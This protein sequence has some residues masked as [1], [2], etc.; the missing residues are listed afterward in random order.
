VR[1]ALAPALAGGAPVAGAG[2]GPAGAGAGSAA[3][4]AEGVGHVAAGGMAQA[5]RTAQRG[6]LTTFDSMLSAYLAYLVL[7][8]DTARAAFLRERAGFKPTTGETFKDGPGGL[9]VMDRLF[10][11]ILWVTTTGTATRYYGTNEELG[12]TLFLGAFDGDA[13]GLARTA[14][15]DTPTSNGTT[16]H[17][18][19][20]LL[21]LLWAYLPHLAAKMWREACDEFVFPQGFSQDWTELVRLFDLQ[22][23]ISELT[24]TEM[25]FVKRLDQPT[26]GKFLQILEDAAQ[27]SA[28]SRWITVVLYSPDARKVTARAAMKSLITAVDPGDAATSGGTLHDLSR[29]DVTC[30]N[31]VELGHFAR[32]SIQYSVIV[33]RG[34]GVIHRGQK[35]A[36]RG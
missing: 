2:A 9:T 16:F 7:A 28:S 4:G 22:C 1:E 23:V 29:E 12:L 32:D 35:P 36:S 10:D 26:W 11:A 25:H 33:V 31:C 3:G 14:L 24:S 27:C 5:Q 8:D 15:A 6:P 19:G 18:H 34:N 30:H 17:L 20:A 13:V 21:A